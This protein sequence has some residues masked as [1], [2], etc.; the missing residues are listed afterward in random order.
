VNGGLNFLVL[1]TYPAIE[2]ITDL[3]YLCRLADV[4]SLASK[5]A[6]CK[7]NIEIHDDL[8]EHKGMSLYI[9]FAFVDHTLSFLHI[10][11]YERPHDFSY[12]MKLPIAL[13]SFD[14]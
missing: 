14:D 12:D 11:K 7:T 10:S 6:T 9:I 4:S 5:I 1:L 13:V 3:L 8:I 2:I